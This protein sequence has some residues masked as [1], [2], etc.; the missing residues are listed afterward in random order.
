[1]ATR[2]LLVW[3]MLRDAN[4]PGT[5]SLNTTATT[6]S[7]GRGWT[8][9]GSV[10][11]TGHLRPLTGGRRVLHLQH[12][13]ATDSSSEQIVVISAEQAHALAGALE[14]MLADV[15]LSR[16]PLPDDLAAVEQLRRMLARARG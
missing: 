12:M 4:T 3:M 8:S 16:P 6:A 5:R 13:P 14:R 9:T 15:R 2:K 10:R 11:K 7:R 1:M